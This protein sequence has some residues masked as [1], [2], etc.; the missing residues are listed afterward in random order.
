MNLVKKC[1]WC[2]KEFS[3]D[4]LHPYQKY[5]S[6]LCRNKI[7]YERSKEE[8]MLIECK[9]C[10]SIFNPR[11]PQV[12]CSKACSILNHH[13][14]SK[15]WNIENW[16][17]FYREH[18]RKYK[19]KK[20][21]E[22]KEKYNIKGRR[23]IQQKITINKFKKILNNTKVLEEES[24]EWLKSKKGTVMKVDAFFP[25]LNLILEYDGEQH[26][27]PV[28]WGG[29][30]KEKALQCVKMQ[31]ERDKLKNK[32]IREKGIKLIRFKFDEPLEDKHILKRLNELG[33]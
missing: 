33:L 13:E 20:W 4:K 19:K 28:C 25:E 32:L 14:H 10:G 24:F 5:C 12:T 17:S 27:M 26:F 2:K 22:F 7:K 15:R 9:I 6:S 8:P 16:E 3:P 23:F 29:M 11:G 1:D 21:Q 18:T 31:Q 30:S